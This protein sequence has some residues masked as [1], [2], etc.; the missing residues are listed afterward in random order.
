MCPLETALFHI[1]STELS[2]SAVDSTP[3][4]IRMKLSWW[5]GYPAIILVLLRIGKVGRLRWWKALWWPFMIHGRRPGHVPQLFGLTQQFVLL[6]WGLWERSW[7]PFPLSQATFSHTGPLLGLCGPQTASL[8][9]G[10]HALSC[11]PVLSDEHCAQPPS[12]DNPTCPAL[13]TPLMSPKGFP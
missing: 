13:N 3:V 7:K 10:L 6:P 11:C 1:A 4:L 8:Q 12:H 9:T 2:V 5:R